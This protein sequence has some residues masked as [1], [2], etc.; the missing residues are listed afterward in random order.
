MLFLSNSHREKMREK[1]RRKES[2]KKIDSSEPI[3][4]HLFYSLI[5]SLL[6]STEREKGNFLP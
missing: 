5:G 2:R 3:I 4:F 6:L 1:K